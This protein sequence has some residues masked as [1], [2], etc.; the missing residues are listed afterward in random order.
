LN[1]YTETL[2]IEE[3][4]K[5]IASKPQ[6]PPEQLNIL[7]KNNLIIAEQTRILIDQQK[8]P[9]NPKPLPPLADVKHPMQRSLAPF[10]L[11]FSLCLLLH[12]Y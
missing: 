12:R 11:S 10:F 8:N 3:Q 7:E 1:S 5:L 9:L 4:R 2:F 6:I